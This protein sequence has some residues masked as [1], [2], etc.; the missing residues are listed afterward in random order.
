MGYRQR[1]RG[2]ISSAEP[3]KAVFARDVK[4]DHFGPSFQMAAIAEFILAGLAHLR[5]SPVSRLTQ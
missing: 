2:K 5:N 4:L 3:S 1:Q